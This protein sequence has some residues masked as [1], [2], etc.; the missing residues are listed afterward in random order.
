[1]RVKEEQKIRDFL[2]MRMGARGEGRHGLVRLIKE[3]NEWMYEPVTGTLDVENYISKC[4]LRKRDNHP[5]CVSRRNY[6]YKYLRTK[7]GM[8]F[9][10]IGKMFNRNHATVMWGIKSHNQ[11]T[12]T[13][14]KTYLHYTDQLRKIFV[15]TNKNY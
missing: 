14:D 12:E 13:K 4:E 15:I 7:H 3:Y 5:H 10:A 2:K 8:T 1:M 6:L 11:W 9:K